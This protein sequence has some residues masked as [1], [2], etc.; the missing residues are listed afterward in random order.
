M[1]AKF[2][3]NLWE[4]ARPVEVQPLLILSSRVAKHLEIRAMSKYKSSVKGL[5]KAIKIIDT[6]KAAN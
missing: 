2:G 6:I 5:Q 4:R 3:S 1:D